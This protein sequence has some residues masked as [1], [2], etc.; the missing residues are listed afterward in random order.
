MRE[1][2]L[3]TVDEWGQAA[4]WDDRYREKIADR[5]RFWEHRDIRPVMATLDR[6][7]QWPMRRVLD[8]GCGISVI[9][10]LLAFWG[11]DVTAIDLS[12]TAIA[13]ANARTVTTADFVACL[14]HLERPISPPHDTTPTAA[15]ATA[16]SATAFGPDADMAWREKLVNSRAAW[17]GSLQRMVGDWNSPAL[18]ANHFDLV[19]GFHA[20]T[21]ASLAFATDALKSFKRVLRPGGVVVLDHVNSPGIMSF[22]DYRA[23]AMA[24]LLA[25]LGFEQ[26]P[27]EWGWTAPADALALEI[28]PISHP[29]THYAVCYWGAK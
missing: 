8:A 11:Y 17:G 7:A 16:A 2:N 28:P 21:G 9:P 18:P 25:D 3:R 5:Y 22:F 20:F 14:Q 23:G 26:L 15:S 12:A 6:F 24:Q 4:Y 29:A 1:W 10:D 13:F 19:L 27:P